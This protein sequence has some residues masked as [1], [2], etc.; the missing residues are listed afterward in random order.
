MI[1]LVILFY[2]LISSIANGGVVIPEVDQD[3]AQVVRLKFSPTGWT[4]QND[5]LEFETCVL[6]SIYHKDHLG[7]DKGFATIK[8][9][10]SDGTEITDQLTADTQCVETRVDWEPDYD[11]EIIGGSLSL[12]SQPITDYRV[13]VIGVPDLTEAQG[14][15]K[16]FIS[17]INM[18]FKSSS[19]LEINGR[20]AKR[21]IYNPTYHTNKMRLKILSGAGSKIKGM[22]GFQYF[23]Q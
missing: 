11:Y 8:L 23:Y 10:K 4:F 13:W 19:E 6:N 5:A 16:Q 17:G 3:S 2:S 12:S 14:G 1:R 22:L 7:A 21:L 20:S 9:F 15:S 18:K